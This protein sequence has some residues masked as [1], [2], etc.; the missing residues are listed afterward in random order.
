MNITFNP[1]AETA[2][3]IAGK[4]EA[5]NAAHGT[6]LTDAEYLGYCLAAE[7]EDER[8]AQVKATGAALTEAA[9]SLLS[10]ADRDEV[11]AF[12]QSKVGA[13]P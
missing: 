2:A 1:D 4:R 10:K 13:Q 8:K 5:H 3:I 12:I 11:I 9:L 7:W 6:S